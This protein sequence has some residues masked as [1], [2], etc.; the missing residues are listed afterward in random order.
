MSKN[1]L[2]TGGAGFIG[3]NYVRRLLL[4]GENVTIFDNLSRKGAE[5]NLEWIERETGK[6]AFQ[7]IRGD[8]RDSD[9]LK[10][11]VLGMDVIVH[12]AAQVAVTTSVDDPV[13]DFGINAGG[14][15]NVLEAARA[16]GR[17]PVMIYASTNKGYG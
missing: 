13:T 8:V 17:Q 15:F 16:H 7:F 5:S 1:Y 9:A 3:S 14:T 4:R 11:A 2:I 12:L 6:G 10:G